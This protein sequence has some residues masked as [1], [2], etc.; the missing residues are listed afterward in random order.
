MRKMNRYNHSLYRGWL[1]FVLCLSACAVTGCIEDDVEPETEDEIAVGEKLPEFSVTMN[2]GSVVGTASLYG[3]P[4]CL[5]FFNTSCEDC[6]NELPVLER[7]YGTYGRDGRVNFV[8][9]SREQD[10]ESVAEYWFANGLT[11]PYSAQ[12]DRAVYTLFASSGIPRIYIADADLMV[13]AIFTD[14]PLATEEDLTAAF[15]ALLP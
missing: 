15:Q 10:A 2:D 14:S 3:K 5:V 8:L 9:V 1:C 4:S 11:M 12:T 13:H 7:A 6:R